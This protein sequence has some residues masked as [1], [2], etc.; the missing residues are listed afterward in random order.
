LVTGIPDLYPSGI[1]RGTP[2]SP[3]ADIHA[4]GTLAVWITVVAL[5]MLTSRPT[6]SPCWLWAGALAGALSVTV[7]S[8]SRAAWLAL[9]VGGGIVA[10]RRVPRRWFVAL[11][12]VGS[13]LIL[14]L[15]LGSSPA[16]SGQGYMGRLINLVRFRDAPTRDQDRIFLWKK[17]MHMISDAPLTGH[18]VGSFFAQSPRFAA[19]GDPLGP[20]PNFAHNLFLQFTAEVGLVGV[21]LALAY[22]V[23]LWWR[24]GPARFSSDDSEWSFAASA[25][26]VALCV[27]QLTSNSLA[28]YAD[29][30][31]YGAWAFLTALPLR[32]DAEP[33]TTNRELA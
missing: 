1:G 6:A 26:L 30:Q 7:L 32:G 9:A 28:I 16:F 24:G 23:S 11:L 27:T 18:G 21:A 29:I 33:P 17:A 13:T 8:W 4:L 2:T 15:N 20:T 31:I 19:A 14:A 3:A 12:L 25:G 10:F 5:A 22:A